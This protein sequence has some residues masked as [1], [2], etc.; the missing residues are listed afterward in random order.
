MSIEVGSIVEGKV[1]GITDFGAF[2]ELEKGKTGLVHISEV[3]HSYV[4]DVHSHLKL[5][6]LVR[7]KVISVGDDGKIGLS[8]KRL[9][10]PPRQ[11][12]QPRRRQ[13]KL[14]FEDKLARFFKESDEK[15]QEL[16]EDR[17]SNRK[18]SN[19]WK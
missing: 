5:D 4:K 19:G 16:S 14:S 10:D 3:A 2:V 7:V 12:Q 11:Q 1:T 9:Q 13:N 18:K 17:Q 6:D 15:Q 8:I